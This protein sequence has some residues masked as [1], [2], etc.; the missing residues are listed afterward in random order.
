MYICVDFDGTIV[1]HAYPDIGKPVPHAIEVLNSD[2]F[3]ENIQ[4][5][6]FTMRSDRPGERPVLTE[7]VNYLVDNGVCLYAV[8]DNPGQNWSASRKVYADAYIDDAALG[9]PLIK[10]PGFNRPCVDWRMIP[11]FIVVAVMKDCCCSHKGMI[12]KGQ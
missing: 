9:C 5:I 12:C 8:N 3:K 10:L 11:K 2:H 4:I 7:A 1:D 6:L